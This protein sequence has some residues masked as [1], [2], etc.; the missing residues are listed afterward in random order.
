MHMYKVLNK[1][2][3]N[4]LNDLFV[5]KSDITECNLRGFYTSLQLPHPKTEKLKSFSFSG[6]KLWNSL[7]IDLGN[8]DTLSAFKNGLCALKL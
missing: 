3:P 1:L 8:G 2:A 7:P 6:A 5:P 4:S